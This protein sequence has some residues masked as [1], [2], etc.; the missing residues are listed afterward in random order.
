MSM[1]MEPSVEMH[2]Q[3]AKSRTGDYDT[4]AAAVEFL[5]ENWREHPSLD[6]VADHIGLSPA[7]F[8]KLFSRWAGISPK[9]FVQAI[10][11]DNAR[12]MLRQSASVLDATYEVGLSGPG[13]LHDLFVS[14][15][16]MT[17][18]DY[19]VGGEG[20]EIAY[21]F[22]ASPFGI[23]VAMATDR[24]LAGIGFADSDGQARS[25]TLF[26]MMGR[27]PRATFVEDPNRTAPYMESIFSPDQWSADRPLKIVLI[28]SEFDVSVWRTLLKI[29]NGAASSYSDVAEHIGNPRAVRA[30]GSAVGR[31]PIPFVVP[32]HRVFRKSGEL[33]G[34]HWGLTRKQA[35]IGWESALLDQGTATIT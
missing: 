21:G 34:Y 4:I 26:E 13:R 24:G 7:H 22:H 2:A 23:T 28:G 29:P 3:N 8:H 31:N 10:A 35:I 6:A 18:G 17:P 1:M 27:W 16:A 5:S 33:G 9:Q 32:C 11:L 19:K 12:A 30:V 14:Y 20:L 15:E 25:D